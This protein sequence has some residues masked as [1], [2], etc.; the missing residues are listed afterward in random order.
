MNIITK[1][2]ARRIVGID[3]HSSNTA[4][5]GKTMHIICYSMVSEEG[6]A[7]TINYKKNL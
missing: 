4:K 3:N 6:D 1:R 5:K 2:R 7:D